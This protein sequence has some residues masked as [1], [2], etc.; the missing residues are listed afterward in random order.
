[1]KRVSPELEAI[2]KFAVDT[3]W[4]DL[5]KSVAHETKR[6][7]LDSIGCG[8][9]GISVDPGKMIINLARRLG[10]PPEAS[11]I[12]IGDK[13]SVSAA[14]LANGQLIN[15]TD[16]DAF[17][18]GG[19]GPAYIIPSPLAMAECVGVSG[20][21]LILATAVAVEIAE[22]VKNAVR[23]FDLEKYTLDWDFMIRGREGYANCNFGAAAGLG[24]LLNLDREKMMV[25][26]SIA[27]HAC[28][29]LTWTHVSLQESGHPLKYGIPG[30]QATGAVMAVFLAQMG[31]VGDLDVFNPEHGYWKFVGYGAW[32]PE[33]IT[34]GLGKQWSFDAGLVTYKPHI[35]CR[36]YQAAMDAFYDIIEKNN[37]TADDIKSVKVIRPIGPDWTGLFRNTEIGNIVDAQFSIPYNISCAAHRVKAGVEWQDI[38]TMRDPKILGFMKKVSVTG[39]E[40]FT[41]HVG[42]QRIEVEAKGK[43]FAVERNLA[44]GGL[45][46]SAGNEQLTDEE[47][48][49]K[50]RHNAARILSEA[51]INRAVDTLW[52]LERVKDVKELIKEITL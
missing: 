2:G 47:L 28:E 36:I 33:N 3:E 32:K 43:T 15:A 4:K 9:T 11:I 17:A 1:M 38:D 50:F 34:N 49:K 39:P 14:V 7:L 52:N 25:A 26:L 46:S 10:G 44:R 5:P 29:V 51:Q 13:V 41:S 35:C 18:G 6:L 27:G 21:D 31:Y 20:K 12:G 37:L 16:F 30:W 42:T 19:H 48:E 40:A 24:K 22:R 45:I 8:F 23:P